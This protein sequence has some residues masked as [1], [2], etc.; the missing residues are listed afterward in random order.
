MITFKKFLEQSEDTRT[1]RQVIQKDHNEDV[2][3]EI[4]DALG[5]APSNIQI[6]ATTGKE[7]LTVNPNGLGIYIDIHEDDDEDLF[8]KMA[9]KVVKTT[10]AK[11]FKRPFEIENLRVFDGRDDTMWDDAPG[12]SLY[13]VCLDVRAL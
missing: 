2:K 12:G 10:I 4:S 13:F 7:P 3:R 1:L 11:Y 9:A 5:V 6:D 8:K